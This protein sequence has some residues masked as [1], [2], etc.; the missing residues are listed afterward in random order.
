MLDTGNAE[1]LAARGLAHTS[2]EQH[3]LAIED[4]TGVLALDPRNRDVLYSRGIARMYAARFESAVED[5]EAIIG[6]EPGNAAARAARGLAR[7]ALGTQGGEGEGKASS[8]QRR[9]RTWRAP[10]RPGTKE[11]EA[12][13]RR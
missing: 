13:R 12:R 3:E 9:A 8:G 5:F 6:I 2:L 7:E 11:G 4:Y 1:T 10:A